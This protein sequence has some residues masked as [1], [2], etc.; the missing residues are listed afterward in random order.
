MLA[1]Q[2]YWNY[3]RHHELLPLLLLLLQDSVQYWMPGDPKCRISES[4]PLTPRSPCRPQCLV[5]S[6]KG[7]FLGMPYIR[8]DGEMLTLDVSLRLS[9][10]YM[11]LSNLLS[12]VCLSVATA[13]AAA[14]ILLKTV[15][16]VRSRTLYPPNHRQPHPEIIVGPLVWLVLVW[17]SSKNNTQTGYNYRHRSAHGRVTTDFFPSE[18]TVRP[19]MC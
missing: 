7:Y 9:I 19:M 8:D 3:H 15:I 18:L 14:T 16:N 17:L 12:T 1:A 6:K 13:S 11:S 10:T 4:Q 5:V 2:L